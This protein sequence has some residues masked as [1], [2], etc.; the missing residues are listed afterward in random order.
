[1]LRNMALILS[2]SLLLWFAEA[3]TFASEEKPSDASFSSKIA[4]GMV[5]FYQR[6]LSPVNGDRCRMRPTCSEYAIH[7]IRK[8]GL[9]V[10]VVLAAD[11]LM[12]EGEEIHRS[13]P[14]QTPKGLRYSDPLEANDFWMGGKRPDV[15]DNGEGLIPTLIEK[16]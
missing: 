6:F 7:A 4:M 15:P 13:L 8:H 14:V 1:M 9:V 2:F 5:H 12:R 10:G 11:R 16:K 3:A